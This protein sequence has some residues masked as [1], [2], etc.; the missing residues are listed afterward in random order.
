MNELGVG[1]HDSTSAGESSDS[2]RRRRMILL[3]IG[4]A[5][6][7]DISSQRRKK[8]LIEYCRTEL[9]KNKWILSK[10]DNNR[11][12]QQTTELLLLSS[13]WFF[14]SSRICLCTT[15]RITPLCGM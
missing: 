14:E 13:A 4:L 1:L 7:M 3:S 8:A 11:V 10:C 9:H 12:T 15:R 2:S 5:A 6:I